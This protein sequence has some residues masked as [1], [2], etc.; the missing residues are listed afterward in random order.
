MSVVYPLSMVAVAQR[1]VAA[2][3][4]VGHN[5]VENQLDMPA[6][7]LRA[8]IVQPHARIDRLRQ[9]LAHAALQR[10]RAPVARN[11]GIHVNHR[12][13]V[14]IAPKPL[15]E[16]RNLVVHEQYIAVGRH[17]DVQ[18]NHAPAGAVIVNDQIVKPHDIARGERLALYPLHQLGIGRHA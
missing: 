10:L 17:L 7:I 12:L 9:Q 1:F 3:H 6:A 14:Q 18:R 5:R 2:I 8:E 11:D 13:A 4:V 15:L 16:R